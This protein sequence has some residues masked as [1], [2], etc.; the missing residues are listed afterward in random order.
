MKT[1]GKS[2]LAVADTVMRM[3]LEQDAIAAQSALKTQLANAMRRVLAESYVLYYAA[4]SSH[5]N[6]E[7]SNFPQYHTFL[8]TIYTEVFEKIDAIAE[9][10]RSINEYAPVSLKDLMS[11]SSLTEAT[12]VDSPES[13]LG[14]ILEMNSKVISSIDTAYRIAEQ[15]HEI[16]MSNFLQDLTNT[17][18]KFGWMISATLKGTK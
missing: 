1:E 10:L 12:H 17:H 9:Q 13:M 15:A 18:K 6:I 7:G 14:R 2:I 4:H 8:Q 5:W 3:L 16:A 11:M